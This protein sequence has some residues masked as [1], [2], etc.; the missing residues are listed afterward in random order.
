MSG[1]PTGREKIAHRF[2]GGFL[3]QKGPESRQGRKNI[4]IM[5]RRLF[6]P[7]GAW[8]CLSVGY[9]PLKRWAILDR[10]CGTCHLV[11]A[12]PPV[13]L[14]TKTVE[15]DRMRWRAHVRERNRSGRVGGGGAD[16]YPRLERSEV[17]AGVN[18]VDSVRSLSGSDGETAI[19]LLCGHHDFR[20]V[21]DGLLD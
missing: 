18:P 12:K 19:G 13:S 9:P 5:V 1:S 6:R 11:G 14:M 20:R 2:I 10:P 16:L 15:P 17:S 7:F 3:R 4:R 8:S 21:A